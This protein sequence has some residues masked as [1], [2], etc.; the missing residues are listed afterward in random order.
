[1]EKSS[2]A[3]AEGVTDPLGQGVVW[4][5]ARLHRGSS[6]SGADAVSKTTQLRTSAILISLTRT[7]GTDFFLLQDL[8][9]NSDGQCEP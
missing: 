3:I 4:F 8:W 6:A 5:S 2:H 9:S 7:V 1:M